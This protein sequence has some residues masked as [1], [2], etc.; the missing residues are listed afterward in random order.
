[1]YF[2]KLPVGENYKTIAP[3]DESPALAYILLYVTHLYIESGTCVIMHECKRT[4]FSDEHKKN[5]KNLLSPHSQGTL[6]PGW[7]YYFTLSRVVAETSFRY[8]L[9]S[10]Y[11][12]TIYDG[13]NFFFPDSVSASQ[14]IPKSPRRKIYIA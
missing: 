2:G 14:I 8:E 11:A 12:R 4:N 3:S 10:R 7:N 13:P 5:I 1:M 9:F 6:A